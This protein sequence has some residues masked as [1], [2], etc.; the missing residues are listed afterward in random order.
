MTRRIQHEYPCLIERKAELVKGK[1]VV[2]A[3]FTFPGAQRLGLSLRGRSRV[4]PLL[5]NRAL[6]VCQIAAFNRGHVSQAGCRSAQAGNPFRDDDLSFSSSPWEKRSD[7]V[8]KKGAALCG[9][10]QTLLGLHGPGEGAFDIA[11][12][13]GFN[14]RGYSAE[15]STGAKGRSLARPGKVNAARH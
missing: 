11:E 12:E 14:Q 2:P 5:I 6:R 3:A 13:L 8:E 9:F 7:L 15:Q 10:E 1:L 4:V